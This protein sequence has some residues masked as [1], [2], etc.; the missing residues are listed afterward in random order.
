MAALGRGL[1]ETYTPL[2]FHSGGLAGPRDIYARATE[3]QRTQESA[4]ALLGQLLLPS[5]SS[6]SSSSCPSKAGNAGGSGGAGADYSS[7]GGPLEL[8]VAQEGWL[9]ILHP[10]PG[11]CPL[12]RTMELALFASDPWTDHLREDGSATLMAGLGAAT[13]ADGGRFPA[14]NESYDHFFDA[15]RCRM[16]HGKALPCNPADPAVCVT[17]E[18][19]DAVFRQGNWEFRYRYTGYERALKTRLE[20]GP[21]FDAIVGNMI[22]RMAQNGPLADCALLPV[23]P[24]GKDGDSSSAADDAPPQ[25]PQIRNGTARPLVLLSTHDDMVGAVLGALNFTGWDWP[26]F[27]SNIVFELWAVVDNS[28][29]GESGDSG[30]GGGD[31]DGGG[32]GGEADGACPEY[33]VRV[34][35]NG[36]VMPLPFCGEATATECPWRQFWAFARDALLWRA[37]EEECGVG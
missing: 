37:I 23:A 18:Q 14:W 17:Q 20:A 2:L 11:R 28:D 34:V 31:V 13:G 24:G 5:A 10:Q 21:L 1:R 33:V 26:P 9:D 19:A 15:L 35:Y 16:C 3:V 27:A 30:G 4:Q 7:C 29:D 6:R 32:N 25:L 22:A 36:R 8:H 12:L